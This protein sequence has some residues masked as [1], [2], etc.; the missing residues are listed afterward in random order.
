MAGSS[1]TGRSLH[2]SKTHHFFLHITLTAQGSQTLVDW[3]H[4]FDCAVHRA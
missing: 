2:R 4:V 1:C 3:R